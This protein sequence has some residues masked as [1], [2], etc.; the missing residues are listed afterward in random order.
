MA[1]LLTGGAGY[2]GSVA[3]DY[4]L[5][6]GEQVVVLDSLTRGHRQALAAEVP[7]YQGDVGDHAL[8]ARITQEHR[9]ESCIHF[10][11][12]AYV[13]ESV[14][15]PKLYFQNNVEQGMALISSLLEAGVRR[16]VLSSTC[17]V[18]GEPEELPI[19]EAVSR[20]PARVL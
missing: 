12:F 16:F 17:A 5:S 6:R 9:L 19:K 2:I 15:D 7:F 8:L 18:Y 10:A 20:A 11:A 3:V 13:G 14:K 1:I 4:L